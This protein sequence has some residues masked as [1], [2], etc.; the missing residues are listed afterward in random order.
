MSIIRGTALTNFDELVA[1]LGGDGR[2]FAAA[3]HL[4]HADIG[5]HD[6]YIS[7][8]HGLRLLDDVARV[9]DVPDLG[10]RLAARQSIEILGPIGLAGRN[11]ATVADAFAIIEKYMAAYSPAIR[12]GIAAHR[13]PALH[14]FEFEYLLDPALPR[15]QAIELSLGVTL[16]VLREFLGPDYRP[17]A[18]HLP[19]AAL[20]SAAD[21]RR[22][23]GAPPEFNHPIAGFTVRT[24]DL[25]RPLTVDRLAH[26]TAVD[27]LAGSIDGRDRSTRT[28][29]RTLV[30][31]LLATGPVGMVDIA[32]QLELHPKTLQRRLS[33]EGTGFGD[34]VDG[35]RREI[36]R[37]LLRDTDLSFDQLSRQLGYAEQSVLTRS[38]R[39]W[40]GMTPSAYRGAG[41]HDLDQHRVAGPDGAAQP[42]VARLEPTPG[43][44]VDAAD[45]A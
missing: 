9:L 2:E 41:S 23:F 26:Q 37:N 32:E 42:S 34:L 25:Q 33:A 15:A 27:F 8:P 16:Q 22:Y 3:A 29:V 31:Q 18:V 28:L 21:Y 4:R 38:C 6:R 35:T 43:P 1:E 40:F 7:L 45:R 10:R 19:H 11:A 39:R 24:A 5:R 30:R 17:T 14:R 36:A 12:T 44:G 13:D 20:T